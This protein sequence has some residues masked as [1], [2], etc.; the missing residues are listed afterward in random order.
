M[1]IA[2]NNLKNY[3]V[4]YKFNLEPVLNQ[5][6]FVEENLQKELAVLKKLLA[7]EKKM[8][9]TFKSEE[10]EVLGELQ[11]RKEESITIS[12]ILLYVSFIEQ[13]SRDIEKQEERVLD[14]E[15]RF[16]QKRE[17]VIEAMKKRKILE[18][19]KEKRLKL[20]QQ[21]VIKNERDFLNEVGINMF[22]RKM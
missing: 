3:L 22:N 13:L 4:M 5:R 21:K 9:A 12:D 2:F 8:L 19:L 10:N 16:D 1:K 7:G 18:K 20:Y 11:Q 6:K 14:A 15:K 17:D